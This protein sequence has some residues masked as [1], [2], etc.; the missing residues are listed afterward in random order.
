[1]KHGWLFLSSML[2]VA[3]TT[4]QSTK[5]PLPASVLSLE[6][7]GRGAD[8]EM[9]LIAVN[10]AHTAVVISDTLGF[11]NLFF[12]IELRDSKGHDLVT[13]RDLF[14]RATRTCLQAG[15]PHRIRF[16]PDRLT[17][18]FNGRPVSE[19]KVFPDLAPGTYRIRA[20]YTARP[21]IS[22]ARCT[23]LE[24]EVISEWTEIVV[25]P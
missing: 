5:V 25:S 14:D 23:P 17:R 19:D 20:K 16:R 12:N 1:M 24:G 2:F 18:R 7:V 22:H 11:E 4:G 8:G 13:G 9:E 6:L 15:E 3:C 10:T 21:D